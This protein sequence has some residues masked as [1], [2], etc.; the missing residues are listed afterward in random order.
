MHCTVL[1]LGADLGCRAAGASMTCTA[2]PS[3]GHL[4]LHVLPMCQGWGPGD[5]LPL[6]HLNLWSSDGSGLVNRLAANGHVLS[7]VNRHSG[8]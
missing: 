8:R 5:T 2:L 7:V 6:G 3:G 4:M 1:G